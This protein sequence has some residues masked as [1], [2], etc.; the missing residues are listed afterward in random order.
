MDRKTPTGRRQAFA[1]KASSPEDL[2]SHTTPIKEKKGHKTMSGAHCGATTSRPKGTEPNTIKD[3]PCPC[4]TKTNHKL[5]KCFSFLKLT[6]DQREDFIMKK[7]LCFGCLSQ[8]HRSKNC[9]ARATCDTCGKRHPTSLHKDK[10]LEKPDDSK[11]A[12]GDSGSKRETVSTEGATTFTLRTN[13]AKTSM[14]VPVWISSIRSPSTEIMTYA[15]LDT[16]SDSSFLLEDVAKVVYDYL[17]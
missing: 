14:I 11:T 13:S 17:Q 4:C 12:N 15:L 10:P 9:R 3:Q 5:E 1:T 8:G 7:G 16:Q 2:K 6:M